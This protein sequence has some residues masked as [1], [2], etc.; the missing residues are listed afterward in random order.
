MVDTKTD[1]DAAP[2]PDALPA[3]SVI[4]ATLN[5]PRLIID[6][7]QSIRA[8]ASLPA[9]LI[10]VDQSTEP[11]TELAALSRPGCEIRVIRSR[12][13]GL[14]AAKNTGIAAAKYDVLAF[15]DD[16][17]L[18]D[19]DWLQELVGALVRSGPHAVVVGHV[20]AGPP[21]VPKARAISLT[22]GGK[23][24]INRGRINADPL[25]GGN[26]ALSRSALAD[27][28]TFDER[29]GAGGRFRS[30]EDNDLGYRLLDSGY[31]IVYVP[32]AV[33]VHRAW[34]AGGDVSK[35]EWTYGFGQGAFYAKHFSLRDKWMLARLI[36]E[37]NNRN[38]LRRT[39]GTRD[40]IYVLGL[41]RGAIEWTV[42]ERL[43]P[44]LKELAG[45][46]PSRPLSGS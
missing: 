31:T 3:C 26:C 15:I 2:S 20:A 29:L 30:A 1:T 44:R 8:G 33:V 35:L 27:V 12:V 23:P 17:M 42:G 46:K 41:A 18:P 4:V 7:V 19:P 25:A 21:E 5:R 37:L 9:E 14:A 34:Q 16:D 38:P 10:V 6:A 43:I 36:A 45:T 24:R 22:P 40:L 28:G 11:N 32:E 39:R 13:R